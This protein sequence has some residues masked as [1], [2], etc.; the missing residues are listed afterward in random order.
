MKL[1]IKYKTSTFPPISTRSKTQTFPVITR[2]IP[3][4]TRDS[5]REKLS[6]SELKP[7][8]PPERQVSCND[9]NTRLSVE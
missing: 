2:D 5:T 8:I 6:E 7:E 9:V 4:C 3:I 1:I